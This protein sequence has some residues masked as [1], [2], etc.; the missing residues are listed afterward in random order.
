MPLLLRLFVSLLLDLL[1]LKDPGHL[2]LSALYGLFL[3]CTVLW[4][5]F[6]RAEPASVR[7][8]LPG[9]TYLLLINRISVLVVSDYFAIVLLALRAAALAHHVL[10]RLG[11]SLLTAVH[12]VAYIGPLLPDGCADSGCCDGF[13]GRAGRIDSSGRVHDASLRRVH[14]SLEAWS[15]DIDMSVT[16]PDMSADIRTSNI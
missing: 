3:F 6:H 10:Q 9:N 11:R 16:G 7:P 8:A 5:C 4:R 14:M 12:A 1:C 2:G 13:A 15:M